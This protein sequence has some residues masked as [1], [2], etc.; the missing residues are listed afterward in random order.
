[1]GKAVRQDL[2]GDVTA[3][4]CV[5]CLPDLAHAAFA[6]LGDDAVVSNRFLG[7]HRARFRHPTIIPAR[8]DRI[9][10][11]QESGPAGPSYKRIRVSAPIALPAEPIPR[12]TRRFG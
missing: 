11:R 1:G 10:R 9:A 12:A 7:A 5:S 6:E 4:F 8:S 2:N 3:E